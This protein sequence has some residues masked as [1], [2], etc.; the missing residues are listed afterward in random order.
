MNI[1]ATLIGQSISFFV[2]IWFCMKY[3]WPPLMNALETRKKSIADGLAAADR[4]RHEHEL[5]ERKAIEILREAKDEASSII[6]LAQK[7]ANEIIEESKNQAR[8]EGDQ[9]LQAANAEIGQEVHRAR[10]QLRGEIAAIAVAGATKVLGRE[11]NQ[12][13]HN[14]L[15]DDLIAQ[16]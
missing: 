9:L 14:E 16:L 3:V 15:F 5:A 6:N 4:G 11:I 8:V 13:A 10:E 2:F 12:E 1:N 7:R